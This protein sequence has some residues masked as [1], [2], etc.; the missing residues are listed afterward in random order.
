MTK[1]SKGG[2]LWK[3]WLCEIY[4][5]FCLDDTLFPIFSNLPPNQLSSIISN[6]GVITPSMAK[7]MD[8]VMFS[9]KL[10]VIGYV[11]QVW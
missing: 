5:T 7:V 2:V 4:S 9:A 8:M 10:Q 6:Q 1:K 11:L 3:W